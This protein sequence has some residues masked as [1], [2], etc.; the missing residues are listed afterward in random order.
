MSNDVQFLLS[1]SIIFTVAVGVLRYKTIDPS[2]H[3]FFYL[4]TISLLV[5]VCTYWLV[6]HQLYNAIRAIINVFDLIEFLLLVWLFHNWGL[7]NF[8][9]RTFLLVVSLYCIAWVILIF[10]V[11]N[12]HQ[13]N[14]YFAVLYAFT[15]ILLAVTVFNKF[16]I[17]ERKAI[18]K[19][20]KFW[21][22]IGVLIFFAFYLLRSAVG[23]TLF[24][25]TSNKFFAQALQEI[26]V[27]PN[28][29]VNL[30]YAIGALCIPKKQPITKAF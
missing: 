19:N 8:K 25:Q 4:A 29:I 26:V 14:Q 9:R 2:Y 24:G 20:P 21:I 30:I 1:L 16:V 27:Y 7:F 13:Y 23:I 17:Q 11:S 15:L 12:F 10:F 28:V 22:S 3:P 6:Q 18:F 5:E